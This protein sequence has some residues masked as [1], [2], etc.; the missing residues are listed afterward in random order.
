MC[1]RYM[2]CQVHLMIM[3]VTPMH[4]K[5]LWTCFVV[6]CYIDTPTKCVC[7]CS[8]SHTHNDHNNSNND[9]ALHQTVAN[10]KN[11][12]VGRFLLLTNNDPPAYSFLF[13]IIKI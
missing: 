11:A 2:R 6:S 5:M 7:V 13:T 10:R 8:V 3:L 12:P 9:K 4:S 1:L